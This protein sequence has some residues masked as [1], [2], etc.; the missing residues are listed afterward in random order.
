[1]DQIRIIKDDHKYDLDE[2]QFL[3]MMLVFKKKFGTIAKNS[4]IEHPVSQRL[5]IK[6]ECEVLAI[7]ILYYFAKKRDSFP[8]GNIRKGFR[9]RI[10]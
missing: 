6:K 8:P 3:R 7:L 10:D 1:M 5:H 2:F 4:D 9:A